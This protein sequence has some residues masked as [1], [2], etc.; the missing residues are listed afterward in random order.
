[1][2]QGCSELARRRP[3]PGFALP[4]VLAVT[5]VV[6]IVFLVAITA[7]AN[8]TAEAAAARARLR[9][10]EHALTAEA[11]ITLMA[12]TEP[13]APQGM[14]I[15]GLRR[16]SEFLGA[17][18]SYASGLPVAELW[19]DGRPYG[20]EVGNSMLVVGLRDQAG[21]INLSLLDEAGLDRLAEATGISPSVRRDLWPRLQDY[22]DADD[23][24]SLNGAEAGDYTDGGPANRKLLTGQEWLSILGVRDAI[25]V[26]RWRRLRDEVVADATE[27]SANINTASSQTLQIRFGLTETEAQAVIAARERAPILSMADVGPIV[28]R[29]IGVDPLGIYAY[30]S[31]RIIF[32]IRD[33][34]S[35][36]I[37]RGRLALTPGDPDQPFWIDQTETFEGPRRTRADPS[38]APAFPYA[39]D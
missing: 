14:E 16:V 34:Q 25:D 1:M 20:L 22:I 32:T 30:P 6:T 37:Y 36:W 9:F 15:G 17:T 27:A 19:L 23:L 24:E 39:P 11:N 35:S 13:F 7:L 4:A 29:D 31:G 28:G 8:L 38:D 18:P 10:M 33:T 3:R 26:T 21:L 5:G 2:K 12:A